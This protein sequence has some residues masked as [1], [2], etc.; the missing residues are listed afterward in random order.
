M[1]FFPIL[2]LC[3]FPLTA[4]G[5]KKPKEDPGVVPPSLSGGGGGDSVGTSASAGTPEPD[6]METD[7]ETET[8]DSVSKTLA[9]EIKVSPSL[10]AAPAVGEKAD[11]GVAGGDG[12]VADREGETR[13]DDGKMDTADSLNTTEGEKESR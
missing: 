12:G 2:F 11:D 13:G 3:S 7:P 5:A 1:C 4:K 8:G 6:R 9:A 10:A